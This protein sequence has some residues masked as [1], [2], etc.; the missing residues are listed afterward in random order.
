MSNKLH[1]LF[2]PSKLDNIYLIYL[3]IN[4]DTFNLC[5]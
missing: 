1:E 4:V 5:E 2:L 3:K